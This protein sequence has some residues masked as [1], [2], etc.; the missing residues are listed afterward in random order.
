MPTSNPSHRPRA[1]P[2]IAGRAALAAVA[3]LVAA[4]LAA[5]TSEAEPERA[6]PPA[7]GPD[8]E[9]LP[10]QPP[11][12]QDTPEAAASAWLGAYHRA[13]WDRSSTAWIDQVR[14]VVTDSMHRRNEGLRDGHTGVD[15]QRFVDGHCRSRVTDVDAVIPPEAPG[16]N[17]TANVQVAGS[18]LTT[19]ETGLSGASGGAP[20]PRRP[21]AATVVVVQHGGLWR[22][23]Q[24]L[25]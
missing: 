25:Y 23:D 21:V 20:Q 8:A 3:T 13:D 2:A 15:W 22:V 14:P 7:A 11:A 18:E 10:P 4:G 17:R 6:G 12:G 16:D 5:C 1:R 19:C 24:H 9:L